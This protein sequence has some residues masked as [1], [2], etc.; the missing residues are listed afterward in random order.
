MKIAPGLQDFTKFWLNAAMGSIASI[1]NIL[2][3]FK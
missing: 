3:N 1:T 2:K